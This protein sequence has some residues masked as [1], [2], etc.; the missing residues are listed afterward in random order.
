MALNVTVIVV[1]NGIGIRVQILY[2]A[3]CLLLCTNALW[4]DMN[5]SLLLLAM[6][7]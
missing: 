7:K 5:P 6:S 3:L 4:K 1:R 2:E